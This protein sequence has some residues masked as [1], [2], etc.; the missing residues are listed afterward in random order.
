MVAESGARKEMIEQS[1]MEVCFAEM[2]YSFVAAKA[3]ADEYRHIETV[4]RPYQ[5]NQST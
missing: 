4:L 2:F 5:P 3:K 1:S